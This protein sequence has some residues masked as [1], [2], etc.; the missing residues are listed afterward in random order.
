MTIKLTTQQIEN[1]ITDYKNQT[2]RNTN[3]KE[4]YGISWTTICRI[5][6]EKNVSKR[7]YRGLRSPRE[8]NLQVGQE[9]GYFTVND[10][11]RS[12]V[13]GYNSWIAILTCNKCG[14]T[15]IERSPDKLLSGHTRTCGCTR[16]GLY[17]TKE[18]HANYS[19]YKDIHGS[20]WCQ[21][22]RSTS[23]RSIDFNIDI[24]CCWEIF[25][26]Q[27]GKCIYS[28]LP[29][30]FGVDAQHESTAS[31]DRID[32]EKPY[33]VDNIQWVHKN[34]N[35]MKC[36]FDEEKFIKLCKDISFY[37][38]PFE[39]IPYIQTRKTPKNFAG[40]GEIRNHKFSS[41]CYGAKKRN[42][43]MGLSINQIWELF[44]KQG[45]KCALTGYPITF[46]IKAVD[47]STAS[48]DRIDSA[49]GYIIEN[50]Q[51]VHKDVNHIKWNFSQDKFFELCSL[52]A[53]KRRY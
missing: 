41:I 12:I 13:K 38:K 33:N 14:N 52:V 15:G 27:Q 24:K 2:V 40:I 17:P 9:I 43:V 35:K 37:K 19:G 7:Q 50:V 4:L 36:I 20:F 53:S 3:C 44:I 48:L 6:K 16:K 32:S 49:K 45:G 18:K 47:E 21:V 10:I 34:I 1:I 28:D 8:C 22:K 23:R 30:Y 39:I 11:K 26:K 25:E 46:G 31:L 51:W 5:I 29:I 42:I